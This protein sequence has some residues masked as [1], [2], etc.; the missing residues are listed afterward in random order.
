MVKNIAELRQELA[1]V[2]EQ[3]RSGVLSPKHAKELNNAA[4]KII[5]SCKVQI[6]YA[7]MREEK[8]QIDFLEIGKEDQS[9]S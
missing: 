7:N 2:F 8:V 3:L 4:G 9:Q 5:N 1:K 6:D